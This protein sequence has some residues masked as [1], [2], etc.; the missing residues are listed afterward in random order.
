MLKIVEAIPLSLEAGS[1]EVTSL[2]SNVILIIEASESS[3]SRI[4]EEEKKPLIELG[5]WMDGL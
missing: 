1:F 4:Q 3:E 2:F 5:A